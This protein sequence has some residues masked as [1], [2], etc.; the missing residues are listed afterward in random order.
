MSLY[1]PSMAAFIHHFQTNEEL[2]IPKG[3][4]LTIEGAALLNDSCLLSEKVDSLPEDPN[5]RVLAIF[6][7]IVQPLAKTVCLNTSTLCELVLNTRVVATWSSDT[8][9]STVRGTLYT[10]LSDLSRLMCASSISTMTLAPRQVLCIYPILDAEA[11]ESLPDTLQKL[12]TNRGVYGIIGALHGNN[13]ELCLGTFQL[14]HMPPQSCLELSSPNPI[15]FAIEETPHFANSHFF[16][17]Y[18]LLKRKITIKLGEVFKLSD[19]RLPSIYEVH[20]HS[21]PSVPLIEF[22]LSQFLLPFG[23]TVAIHCTTAK[24]ATIS[25][26]FKNNTLEISGSDSFNI[27]LDR[28]DLIADLKSLGQS[29]IQEHQCRLTTQPNQPLYLYGLTQE[30]LQAMPPD[31]DMVTIFSFLLRKQGVLGFYWKASFST[32]TFSLIPHEPHLPM[33]LKIVSPEGFHLELE[34]ADFGRLV[35]HIFMQSHPSLMTAFRERDPRAYQML[36]FRVL[37]YYTC[38]DFRDFRGHELPTFFKEPTQAR[39]WHLAH[40]D[41]IFAQAIRDIATSSDLT[42]IH[43]LL[44]S[45]PEDFDQLNLTPLSPALKLVINTLRELAY[46]ELQGVS[47]FIQ[48]TLQQISLYLETHPNYP[49]L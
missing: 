13:V 32:V 23:H 35:M 1:F 46:A 42:F 44:E 22:V 18:L 30:E 12:L 31:R 6:N 47:P 39:L 19:P 4:P 25:C 48:N 28:G 36:L 24:E 43:T 9:L 45:T 8:L 10:R 14:P 38:E 15:S 40:E 3:Q 26:K 5:L 2:A 16:C 11:T 34:R 33:L 21:F 29:M 41:K 27:V 49:H 17:H 37:F 20:Q 7:R